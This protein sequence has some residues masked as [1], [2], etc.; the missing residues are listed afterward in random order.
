MGN[1]PI[2][3]HSLT[4]R[5][6]HIDKMRNYVHFRKMNGDPYFTQGQMLEEAIDLFLSSIDLEI[7]ERPDEVKEKEKKR[8]G[9]RKVA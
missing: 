4:L 5:T 6:T 1:N 3:T 7:P 9:R 8:T 2:K